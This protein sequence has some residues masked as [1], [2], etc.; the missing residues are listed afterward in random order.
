V[1]GD[2]FDLYANLFVAGNLAA[3]F[4]HDGFVT[5][6]DFDEFVAKFITGGC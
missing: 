6:D 2:D 1:N 5:A 3:D 4:N